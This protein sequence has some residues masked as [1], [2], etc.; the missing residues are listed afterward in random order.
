[1]KRRLLTATVASC[2]T[3][4]TVFETG[5]QTFDTGFELTSGFLPTLTLDLGGPA[6]SE[7]FDAKTVGLTPFNF[8]GTGTASLVT[9]LNAQ[10]GS[11]FLLLTGQDMCLGFDNATTPLA[12][13]QQYEVCFWA[14][15]WD[16]TAQSS[17]EAGKSVN[18]QVTPTVDIYDGA[19][20]KTWVNGNANT[21]TPFA[22]KYNGGTFAEYQAGTKDYFN[23]I[24][25]TGTWNDAAT[26]TNDE[27]ALNWN[28]YSFTFTTNSTSESV[29]ISLFGTATSTGGTAPGLAL[30]NIKLN[31]VPEPTSA[32]LLAASG[33]LLALRRRRN[34]LR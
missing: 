34:G 4:L 1:M 12:A 21:A 24:S 6:G 8:S 33:L 9:G 15:A 2:A 32:T 10:S 5:A 18:V 27:T 20:G 30:D 7:S 28:F 26:A 22:G 23:D 3:I 17:T 16:Y 25:L 11:N 31:A 19:K 29:F 13:N 14:A